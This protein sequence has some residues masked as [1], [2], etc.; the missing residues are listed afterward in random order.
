MWNIKYPNVNN[1]I[2]NLDWVIDK[3]KQLEIRMDNMDDSILRAANQYTDEQLAGYQQQLNE[4]RAEFTQ[5]VDGLSDEFDALK[6]SV[7]QSIFQMER[8]LDDLQEQLEADIAASNERTDLAIQQNNE[9]LFEYLSTELSNIKV[10]NALTGIY[11]TVQEMFN[12]LC[13]LH[14]TDAITYTNLAARNNTYT[15]LANYGMTYTQLALNGDN[16]I[17]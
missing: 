7:N 4:I 5:L 10:L 6:V 3:V 15:Q 13:T 11:V 1:E 8:K 17:Q 14:A 2:L 12:Y 9:Y 16:I